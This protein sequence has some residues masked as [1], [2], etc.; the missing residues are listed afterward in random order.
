MNELIKKI[1]ADHIDNKDSVAD[2]AALYGDAS[3]RRYFR[4]TLSSGKTLIVMKMPLGAA[5]VS[6]EI[7]NYKGPKGELPYIN[8]S[9]YLS[10]KGIPVPK[11]L[12]FD[13]K[14]DALIIEDVGDR[15]LFDEVYQSEDG[16]KFEWYKKA[17]E[18][19]VDLQ[20]KTEEKGDCIAF[21]RS[22][23]GTLLNW[24]FDHFL[25]YGIEARQ[26]TKVDDKFKKE[27][28]EIT[29]RV[30][31]VI[32]G[33]RYRFV[34]RDYQSRNL[35]VAGNKLYV[36]D[37]QDALLGPL[38]YDLVAL[39]RD[40]YVDFSDLL[41]EK[42][43]SYYC[44]LRKIDKDGFSRD[45]DLVTIQRKLKDAGRFVYIDKVKGNPAY[46]K[47]IPRSIEHVKKALERQPEYKKLWGLIGP[48]V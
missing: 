14:M 31:G 36:I 33:M 16:V 47:H 3:Y 41:L 34:H 25:E 10:S 26:N 24:E 35:M 40:S 9:N 22:F 5:S 43:V 32:T 27:F 38:C 2:I 37:F 48:Y 17:I 39:T 15:L 11:I 1:V 7:T 6:E 8:V 42:L 19:L 23:D 12:G 4:A 45:Y 28:T 44:E 30:T 29:R 20:D 18:L 13:K 21:K 46:L